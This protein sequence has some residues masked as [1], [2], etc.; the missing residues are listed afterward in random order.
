MMSDIHALLIGID[1][2][3]PNPLPEGIY[4]PML[5]GCVRDISQV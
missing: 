2:Y 5:G 4:Y 1:F 3:Y